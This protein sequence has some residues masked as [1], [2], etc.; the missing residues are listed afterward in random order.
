MRYVLGL[1]FV[2]CYTI[3]VYAQDTHV[4]FEPE[5]GVHV[6]L[7]KVKV[8][9]PKGFSV[10]Y[11][12]NG[13]VPDKK[14]QTVRGD[15]LLKEN[16]VFRFAIYPP[17]GK[18]RE[19]IHSYFIERAHSLPVISLVADSA[20]FF[21]SLTGIY[22]MGPNADSASP[23]KGANFWQDWERIIN[24]E[25]FDT[26]GVTGFNQPAGIK[27]F[28]GY[29]K[30]MPQ[31]SLA[32]YARKK[33]DGY[34]KFRYR[35]FPHLKF[36]KYNN[37][38]LRNAGGDMLGAHMRDVY[39]SQLI[40]N[41]GLSYQEY[42]PVS[43]YINGVYWGKY[44]LR[45]KINEHFI[46]AHYG[47]PKDSII[48]M[49]HNAAYQHGSTKSYIKFI[50]KLE[51]LYLT[52]KEAF[53]YVNRK[54]DIANY[55]T[56]NICQIYTANGDAGGNIRYYKSTSDTAK[57]RWVFYDLDHAMNI[58]TKDD[59]LLNSI[60]DFTTYKDEI[61]PNPPWSTLIIRK[62]LDNDSIKYVYI[63]R[64]A[65]LLHTNFTSQRAM[66]LVNRLENEVKEEI[67]YHLKRWNVSQRRYD[68]SLTK[69]KS[70]A[71][72]RPAV[73][74]K[75][76]KSHFALADT[77]IVKI[78]VDSLQGYVK[79]NSLKIHN[80]YSGTYFKDVPIN[81]S[82]VSHVDYSFDY[83]ENLPDFSTNNYARFHTDTL[84][85]K[86]VFKRRPPSVY[87]HKILITEVDALQGKDEPS[88]DWIELHN[89]SSDTINIGNWQL[90]DNIDDHVFTIPEQTV[91]LPYT[92]LVLAKD[93]VKFN[94]VYKAPVLGNISFG[95]H[96]DLDEIRLYDYQG[97]VVDH[98]RLS[99]LPRIERDKYNWSR[100]DYRPQT[101]DVE[102]WIREKASPG[103]PGFLYVKYVLQTRK[104]NKNK[105]LFFITGI[106]LIGFAFLLVLLRLLLHTLKKED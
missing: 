79:F 90:R 91:L 55:I 24:V 59:Y 64:F 13:S 106:S 88:G 81:F 51:T 32:L 93:T 45:E 98:V 44:N 62:L 2:V 80:A 57:W 56:Y 30:A 39:A 43:V 71:E 1:L 77:F 37:L 34:S 60:V 94:S 9:I 49:K 58:S 50:N 16:T 5:G 70:F 12:I 69:L 100:I 52:N 73:L 68:N 105:Q 41:T 61:W 11:T 47:Y 96:N 103:K 28:G 54:I 74:W 86:P 27:I 42:R 92:F 26:N 82:V 66:N 14:S 38:V 87:R 84:V 31:K 97:N 63:N 20:H 8:T 19:V 33:Y 17:K 78:E 89:F 10:F 85:L 83:W 65:D 18:K 40:K 95:I 46:N 48:I 25:F 99:A 22:A 75:H 35:I 102:N 76:L 6:G 4:L 21:D 29:S 53:A 36:K 7:N 101:F 23:Y 104:D 15:L 72:K 67:P 3:T